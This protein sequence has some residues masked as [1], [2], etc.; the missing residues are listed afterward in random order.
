MIRVDL[1]QQTVVRVPPSRFVSSCKISS[2]QLA[3]LV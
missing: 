1:S 2:Q 3:C